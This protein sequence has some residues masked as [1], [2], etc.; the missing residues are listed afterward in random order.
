[1]LKRNFESKSQGH[2][3]VVGLARN[4]FGT[5]LSQRVQCKKCHKVDYVSVRVSSDKDQFCRDCAESI[6]GAF[7]GRLI[8]AKTI[9]I[10]E[11][12]HKDFLVDEITAHKKGLCDD[13]FRGFEIWRGRIGSRSSAHILIKTGIK[14][15][16]RKVN[17][18]N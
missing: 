4:E 13:C 8:E 17:G 15:T 5:R 18:T 7:E 2:R 6:L 14:T 9:K 10:C 3:R 1:M 12:C 16:I 11:Q